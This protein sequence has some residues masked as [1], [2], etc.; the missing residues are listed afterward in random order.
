[1]LLY[2]LPRQH[3]PWLLGLLL[4]RRLLLLVGRGCGRCLRLHL[5]LRGPC[6]DLPLLRRLGIHMKAHGRL[7]QL[8]WLRQWLP[9]HGRKGI[10]EPG[11]HHGIGRLHLLLLRLQVC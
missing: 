10:I 5:L 9:L 3:H 7:L 1:M 6:L 2:Q 4:L 11:A 8:A